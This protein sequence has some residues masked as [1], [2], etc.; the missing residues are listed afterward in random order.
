MRREG[1]GGV[2]SNLD[3]LRLLATYSMPIVISLGAGLAT[4]LGGS[5]VL[6]PQV[7]AKIPESKLLGAALALSAGVMLYVSFIE[8]FGKS[9]DAIS[10]TEGISEAGAAISSADSL[11]TVRNRHYTLIA[12]HNLQSC[13]QH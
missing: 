3:Q 10:S 8:I 4:V 13:A 1:K 7:L 6:C 9:F 11:D 12:Q 2:P 5:F